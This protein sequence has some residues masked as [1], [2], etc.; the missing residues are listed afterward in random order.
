MPHTKK[1]H[2]TR[3]VCAELLGA[4]KRLP[5]VRVN[6]GGVAKSNPDVLV[7]VQCPRFE[8]GKVVGVP[9]GIALPDSGNN[10]LR[11]ATLDVLEQ[12]ARLAV[13]NMCADCPLN[14]AN[15]SDSVESESAA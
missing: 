9:L 11:K 6:L 8:D 2:L 15:R 3:E 10:S 5:V 7:E 13:K 14:P 1:L 4:C 12:D